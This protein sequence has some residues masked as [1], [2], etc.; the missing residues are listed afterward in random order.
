MKINIKNISIKSICA[1]LFISLFLSCNNGIEELQREKQF[2]SSLA[3]LGNDFLSV[4][5]SF[6]DSLGGVLGFNPNTKKSEVGNYFKNIQET[7]QG[8]KTGLNNIVTDMKNQENPNAST[9]EAAVKALNEKLDKIIEGAKTVSE[10]IGTDATAPIG[11]VAASAAAG[12]V[13]IGVDKLV[14][15]IKS[16]VGVVLKDK[17]KA[18]AGDNK[19]AEDGSTERNSDGSVKLFANASAGSDDKKAAADAAK[20][21]GAVTGAD[22]LQAMVKDNGDAA[23]L[24]KNSS[25]GVTAPKDAE[26]AGGIALRA[27][28]KEG[29]FANGSSASEAKKILD[30]AV[31]SALTKALDTLTIAIRKTIDEGLKEVK[32]VM[33]INANIDPVTSDDRGIATSN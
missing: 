16:I 12:A 11:N 8:V 9:V 31:T 7:V 20:A 30:G 22:I 6:G 19:K 13:G 33:N 24:A 27:M 5:T 23:K 15:G 18:D 2:Y 4:F 10:A 29:K 1:T 14:Q 28:A 21:I 26:V 3:N 32:K 25:S 17:G